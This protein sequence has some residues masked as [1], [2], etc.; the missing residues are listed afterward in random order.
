MEV[1]GEKLKASREEKGLSLE[2]VSEDLK[3][4]IKDLENIEIGN[5]KYF[6]DVYSLK[7]Y[8]HEY[9]KYLGLDTETL[10]EEFNEFMF[11]YTSKIPVDVIERISKQ[12][13]KEEMSKGALSPY[14]IINRKSSK[15]IIVIVLIIISILISIFT[16]FYV[17]NREKK[18]DELV[19]SALI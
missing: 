7:N 4:D 15:K 5:R 1:I 13:E 12:K 16:V 3:I 9:A 18:S 2:E 6:D 11:E 10:V 19:F 17:T 8:I 14:T